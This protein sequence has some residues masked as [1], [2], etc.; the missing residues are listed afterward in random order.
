MQLNPFG[1]ENEMV[2][3]SASSFTMLRWAETLLCGL[4]GLE[5]QYNVTIQG[6]MKIARMA[7]YW[8]RGPRIT[9]AL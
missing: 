6:M 4:L 1:C 8:F 7:S 2:V 5:R 9:C 3:M